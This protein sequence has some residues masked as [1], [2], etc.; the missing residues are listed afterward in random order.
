MASAAEALWAP[1]AL[2]LLRAVASKTA[3]AARQKVAAA[4]RPITNVLP[5]AAATQATTAAASSSAAASST[6][7][8]RPIDDVLRRFFS[9][10]SS[11]A[12]RAS[13]YLKA[14]PSIADEA[15]SRLSRSTR[16]APFASTLR[17]S[18]TGGAFPRSAGGYGLGS[19]GARFFSHGP[20]ASAEVVQNVSQA[21]RAFVLNG[22]RARYDGV[23]ARGNKRY[24]AVSAVEDEMARRVARVATDK[25]AEGAYIDF[26]L[27]PTV[28]AMSP[29]LAAAF[30]HV[31][32]SVAP[33]STTTTTL[34][35]DGFLDFL[36][37]DFE[38]A[39]RDLTTILTD[40][41]RLAYLGDLPISMEAPSVLRVRFPGVDAETVE[42]LCEDAGLRRGFVGEDAEF[43][44]DPGVDIAL[45]FPF[46][47]DGSGGG[48]DGTTLTSPGGSLRSL[49]GYSDDDSCEEF[50][51]EAYLDEFTA[52]PWLSDPEGVGGGGSSPSMA[53]PAESST[54]E[55]EGVEGIYRFLEACDLAKGRF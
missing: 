51:E 52:R 32:A 42:R 21:M 3:A 31:K 45:R 18:L 14:R 30:P 22:K 26:R 9:S 5:S 54:D 55:F 11:S 6:T 25:L 27:S 34:N 7:R 49:T 48:D 39:A 1:V 19:G 53:T 41:K 40:L 15:V 12:G 38:R 36:A 16:R 44:D 35:T 37:G 8:A 29:L 4:V 47:P 24:R 10:L 43:R 28:T 17:P 2:R 46:A 20:T 33:T 23:N 50:F 13:P